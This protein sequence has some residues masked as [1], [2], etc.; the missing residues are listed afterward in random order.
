MAAVVGLFAASRQVR[1]Q[2]DV[3]SPKRAL[4]NYDGR[5][6]EEVQTPAYLWAARVPLAPLYFVHEFVLR[7][8]LGAITRAAERADIPR[9]A[10]D[11]FA[12]GPDHKA[13]VVPV[14]LIEFGFLP[15]VGLFGFWDDAFFLKGNKLRVHYEGWPDGFLSGDISDRIPIGRQSMLHVRFKG[16]ERPDNV[17]YGIGPESEQDHQARFSSHR[18]DSFTMLQWMYWRFS[19]IELTLGLRKADFAA[20]N[21]WGDPSIEQSAAVGRFPVPDGYVRGYTAPYGRGYVALDTRR[22]PDDSGVR[23]E[24]QVEYSADVA[25]GP[26]TGWVRY[27]GSA[28]GFLDLHGQG[29]VLSLAVATSFADPLGRAPIP[30]T[31]LVMLGGDVWMTGFWRGRLLDRSSAVAALEYKWPIAAGLNATMRGVVGNVFGTHL[32]RFEPRLFRLSAAFGFS[33]TTFPP[34]EMLVGFGTDTFERGA[35]IDSVRF[36]LGI[37]ERL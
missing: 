27:G 25:H 30:F 1:A 31:E 3:Q 19:K 6:R 18:F 20:S 24:G 36:S 12:F 22:S 33:T 29:R 35:S 14:G 16:W 7:R 32:E 13:G 34:L 28:T 15:S 26:S 11:F 8:P 10:Y 9:K 17:F 5:G 37:L 21:W 23:V 4:P 2:N